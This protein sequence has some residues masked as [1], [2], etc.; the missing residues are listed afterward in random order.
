[1]SSIN[2]C[3]TCNFGEHLT[4]DGY[5]GDPKKLNDQDIVLESL[6]ELPELLGMQKLAEPQIYFVPDTNRK[7]PGGWSGF[8]VIVESHISIHTFPA[9]KFVSIDVYTC[10]DGL[11]KEFVVNYFKAKFKLQDVE[12]NFIKRGTKYPKYNLA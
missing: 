11:N 12:V 7:D 6:Y 1:M 2:Y 9:R 10:R 5:G 4:L 3:S 8:V